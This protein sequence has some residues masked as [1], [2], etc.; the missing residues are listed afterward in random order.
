MS[1]ETLTEVAPDIENELF[2]F[3]MDVGFAAVQIPRL[4]A[5]AAEMTAFALEQ[6]LSFSAEPKES[7]YVVRGQI[8]EDPKAQQAALSS[9]YRNPD[10]VG[11]FSDPQIESCPICPGDPPSGNDTGVANLLDVAQ[12]A[13]NGLDG[14]GVLVAVVDSGVNLAHLRA[15]GRTPI[16]DAPRSWTPTGVP[17]APGSHAVGHGTMCAFDA[18]IAAPNAT[19]L[20]HAVLLSSASGGSAMSGVLSDAVRSYSMLLG[21][22]AALPAESRNLVVNNSWGMYSPLWDFPVGHPGNYSDNPAHPFNVIVASLESAGADIFFAAGNCG[23]TCPAAKCRFGGSLPICGANSHPKVLTIAG[24]DVNKQWVGYSSQGPGRLSHR[25]PN[26]SA[27]THFSGSGVWPADTGTSAA[28]P[29]AAGFVAAVRTAYPSSKL[30]PF[31]LRS[32]LYKTSED[33]GTTGFDFD[34]G[35]GA[36]NA[37]ALLSAI[38]RAIGP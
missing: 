13:R 37:S 34:Y 16:L 3:K 17:T 18:G 28:C 20:D 38:Q 23:K 5:A 24:I 32:L 8:P 14:K 25:K 15:Q 33:L 6:P 30:S 27:Y 21:I 36:I 9:L 11:V 2:G 35:W 31:E 12:L 26:L 22:I 19:L 7:T 10:V 29:V 4:K 1:L